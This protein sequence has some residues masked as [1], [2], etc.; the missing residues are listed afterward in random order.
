MIIFLDDIMTSHLRFFPNKVGYDTHN[1]DAAPYDWRLPPEK[2]YERDNYFLRLK[3][4]IE[5]MKER[6]N[7]K[8]RDLLFRSH[9]PPRF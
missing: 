5:M 7:E 9:V 4:L 8:A 6:N 2:L 3:H 1:L